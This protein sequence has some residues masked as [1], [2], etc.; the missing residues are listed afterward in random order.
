LDEA[1]CNAC[2]TTIEITWNK[3]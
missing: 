2:Q 3:L 1:V